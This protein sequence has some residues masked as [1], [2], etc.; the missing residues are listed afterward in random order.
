M[1]TIDNKLKIDTLISALITR[2]K[3]VFEY[4]INID[5]YKLAIEAEIENPSM[6]GLVERMSELYSSETKQ[7]KTA[8]LMLT[9]IEI[10]LKAAKVDIAKLAQA[11]VLELNT[12]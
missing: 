5:S 11:K 3:E 8:Q 6:S 12:A 10:Q 1:Y 2:E 4:Q 9:V 7:Q